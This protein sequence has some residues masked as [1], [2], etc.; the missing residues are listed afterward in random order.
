MINCWIKNPLS[1][2]RQITYRIYITS[3]DQSNELHKAELTRK[4]QPSIRMN[5]DKP[6]MNKIE[7]NM[8]VK[9]GIANLWTDIINNHINDRKNPESTI[10]KCDK[11]K[12]NNNKTVPAIMHLI[13]IL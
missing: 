12:N 7:I 10:T 13:E 2:L 6:L 9:L 11:L 3:G 1:N 5:N 4:K 8:Q